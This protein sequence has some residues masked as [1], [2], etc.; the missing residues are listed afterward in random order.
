MGREDGWQAEVLGEDGWSERI[1]GKGDGW[2]EGMCRQKGWAGRE[3]ARQGSE[4]CHQS[5]PNQIQS[6]WVIK[7]SLSGW[8]LTAHQVSD[9]LLMWGCDTA[10]SHDLTLWDRMRS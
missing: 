4:Q 5:G 10:A 7:E 3:M 1:G 8:S 6:S 9:G 2:T